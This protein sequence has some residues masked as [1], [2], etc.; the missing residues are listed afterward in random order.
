M[1]PNENS[2][3]RASH[4][5]REPGRRTR[6][7]SGSS[8]RTAQSVR[9]LRSLLHLWQGPAVGRAAGV[10]ADR[11][12]VRGPPL[13]LHRSRVERRGV[14]QH[15]L[16]VEHRGPAGGSRVAEVRALRSAT[17]RRSLARRRRGPRCGGRRRG[18]P[19]CGHDRGTVEHAAPEFDVRSSRSTR[20][21]PRVRPAFLSPVDHS[22]SSSSSSTT[23]TLTPS[24]SGSPR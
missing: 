9:S 12:G 8:R 15:E 21:Q 22:R 5:S 7:P 11:C 3:G 14:R 1:T 17:A 23:S 24:P 16:L 13:R 19:C 2:T 20:S 10:G 18:S 4:V 6:R